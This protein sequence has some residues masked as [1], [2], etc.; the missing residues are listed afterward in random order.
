MND[1]IMTSAQLRERQLGN[2][3][4]RAQRAL[5]AY[6]DVR[7]PMPVLDALNALDGLRERQY[8]ADDVVATA[9]AELAALDDKD[10]RALRAALRDGKAAPKPSNRAPAEAK[11]AEAE[12]I[13]TATYQ[14]MAEAASGVRTASIAVR[15]E[16]RADVVAQVEKTR[17]EALALATKLAASL[18]ELTM[19]AGAVE[20]MDSDLSQPW[21]ANSARWTI[22][23]ARG[24][25]SWDY[26]RRALQRIVDERLSYTP[27]GLGGIP[28]ILSPDYAA[29]AEE[30]F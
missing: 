6:V 5:P 2:L 12:R 21:D 8:D 23:S 27:T 1:N 19:L 3:Y 17:A 7:T 30:D 9:R 4:E 15:E 14:V 20:D 16:W 29:D 11:V 18:D 26:D 10:N 13:Q 25:L 28:E 24:G 22:M